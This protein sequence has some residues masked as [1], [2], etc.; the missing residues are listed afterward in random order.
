MKGNQ[1]GRIE[2]FYECENC[3]G[4]PY[5]KKCTKAEGNRTI[6]LNVELAR[7]HEEVLDNLSRIHDALL[8]MNRS[9]QTEGVFGG[10]KRNRSYTRAR[11]RCL[12]ELFL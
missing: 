10:I 12:E 9:I 1:Y 7:F 2:E 5:K 11:R 3:S 6:R 8:R 4:C